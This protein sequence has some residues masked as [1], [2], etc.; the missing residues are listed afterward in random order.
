MDDLYLYYE[1]T[2][3]FEEHYNILKLN[4]VNIN[5]ITSSNLTCDLNLEENSKIMFTIPYDEGWNIL[6][7]GKKVNKEKALDD[8]ILINIEKGS[9]IIDLK[10]EPKGLK[11]GIYISLI[12]LFVSIIYIVLREKIWA[13]YDKFKEI[14]NYIIVGVLTT[15]VSLVSYFIFSRILNIDKTIYFI[16]ANTISWI[17]SVAFAYITN[18]LYVFES[19]E[20]GKKTLLKEIISFYL[21]RL[22]TGV[23]CDL[24]VFALMVKTFKINDVLSKLVTQVIV[25]VLNYVLSKLIVFKQNK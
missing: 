22:F 23:V 12:S 18:K 15:I 1:N 24:G 8:L 9:H 10:Y 21:A 16:L 13:I 11:L 14:F 17:L 19:K 7:D 20:T 4:E 2:N 25:I 5:K 3:V 6:V